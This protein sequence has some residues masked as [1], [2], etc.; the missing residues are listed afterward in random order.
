FAGTTMRIGPQSHGLAV[1]GEGRHRDLY[2]CSDLCT[3]IAL[4]LEPIIDVLPRHH[5]LREVFEG[6]LSRARGAQQRLKAG[7]LTP[8]AADEIAGKIS[9]DIGRHSTQD[10]LF[11]ALM[12][13]DSG[14]LRSRGAE[15]RQRLARDLAA[16]ELALTGQAQ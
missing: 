6:L 9:A 3:P 13:T 2:F 1:A 4:K 5:P 7:K 12:N 14:L 15:V 8:E 11:A 16:Q 10:E